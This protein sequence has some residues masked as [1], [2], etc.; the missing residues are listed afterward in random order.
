MTCL[1]HWPHTSCLGP[2][3]LGALGSSLHELM[4]HRSKVLFH[5]NFENGFARI[6]DIP[7]RS[8][9]LQ[10][11]RVSLYLVLYPWVARLHMAGLPEP[12]TPALG[13]AASSPLTR[14]FVLAV[15]WPSPAAQ[16]AQTVGRF[17]M[18][19]HPHRSCSPAHSLTDP[20]TFPFSLGFTLNFRGSFQR[21]LW[22]IDPETPQ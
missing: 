12:G 5:G 13:P 16:L 14:G 22:L 18:Q 10:S 8:N 15:L 20:F 21:A 9:S 17:P 7:R 19:Q 4:S 2:W 3:G 1:T 11:E 6:S